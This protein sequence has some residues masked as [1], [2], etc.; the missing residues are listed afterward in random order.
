M[1]DENL[2]Q[3]LLDVAT[4]LDKVNKAFEQHL[5]ELR[6]SGRDTTMI[7]Q[8]SDAV[9][10]LRDSSSMYLAWAYHYAGVPLPGE[11]TPSAGEG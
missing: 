8:T 6:Q 1:S 4:A 5:H 7:R 9:R 10:S 3:A 2:K 11:Q